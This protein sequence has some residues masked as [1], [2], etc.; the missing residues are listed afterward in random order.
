MSSKWSHGERGQD[1]VLKDTRKQNG[2][3]SPL[4]GDRTECK[5]MI[6]NK[7]VRS[8]EGGEIQDRFGGTKGIWD[9]EG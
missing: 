4:K 5:G 6:K 1:K 9:V 8:C 7:L 3:I 2:R